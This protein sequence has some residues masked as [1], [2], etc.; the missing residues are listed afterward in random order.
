MKVIWVSNKMYKKMEENKYITNFHLFEEHEKIP[1]SSDQL[2]YLDEAV[3]TG[4]YKYNKETH[5]VD[6]NGDVLISGNYFA[7]HDLTFIPWGTINGDFRIRNANRLTSLKGAPKKITGSLNITACFYLKS[8]EHCTQ[9]IEEYVNVGN[10]SLT[11]LVGLPKK[12]NGDFDASNN[13]LEN[14]KGCPETVWG[15][16]NVYN[17]KLT[18]LEYGP[19]KVFH[20]YDCSYNKLTSLKGL[21]DYLYALRAIH[22]KLIVL[23]CDNIKRIH[24]FNVSSNEEL[25]SL[26]G[27]PEIVYSYSAKDCKALRSLKGLH[28]DEINFF[29]YSDGRSEEIVSFSG[30]DIK[31]PDYILKHIKRFPII[32]GLLNTD[33]VQ[34]MFRKNPNETVIKLKDVWSYLIENYPEFENIKIPKKYKNILDILSNESDF[35]F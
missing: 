11:S 33:I 5:L 35:G 8:L 18:S 26:E 27:G 16:F 7:N 13:S 23:E 2:G 24:S 32:S 12:I 22:N 25:I 28:I 6:V 4:Y 21:P 20:I 15:S 17:N 14:L 29:V 1:L 19:K 30:V 34:R 9:N 31:D 3:R 10:N